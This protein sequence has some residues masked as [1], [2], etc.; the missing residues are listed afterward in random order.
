[1]LACTNVNNSH[2]VMVVLTK[3]VLV[4]TDQIRLLPS[5]YT[6]GYGRH[7]STALHPVLDTQT[8]HNKN[9]SSTDSAAQ[10]TLHCA[11]L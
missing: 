3:H 7:H 4:L 1:M 10:N 8:V 9:K 5:Q 2:G 6:E 11:W